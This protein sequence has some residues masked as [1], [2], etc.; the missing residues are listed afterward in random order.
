MDLICDQRRISSAFAG[1]LAAGKESFGLALFEI[2]HG[3]EIVF[4]AERF[5]PNPGHVPTVMY[6]RPMSSLIL[7]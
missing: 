1:F 3:K 4:N 2:Q 5:K 7:L 6:L